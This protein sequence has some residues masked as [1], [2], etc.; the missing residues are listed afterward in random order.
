MTT[1]IAEPTAANRTPA[2]TK[3]RRRRFPG[4]AGM[5]FTLPLMIVTAAVIAYPLLWTLNLSF[6]SL[7]LLKRNSKSHY[8]GLSNY[9]EVLGSSEFRHAMITTVGFVV[10]MI[11]LEFIL[12]LA[13]ALMLNQRLRGIST[14][15][16]IFCLPLLLAPSVAGLQFRFL[17]ADQY[18][19]INAILRHVGITGPQWLVSVWAARTAIV[20]SDLWLATPFVVLVLL[21]GMASLPS[22]PFEAARIDGARADQVLRYVMLPMLRPAILIILVIRLADGFRIF[23]LV[24]IL[25]GGGP[26]TSTD[27]MSTYIYR[28]T[29]V[30]AHFAQGAAAS[31]I[32]VAV[33]ALISFVC[34]RL[35][36]PRS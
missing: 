9:R 8:V 1:R 16:L 4:R 15:R 5:L 14:F 7:N 13:I 10:V 19:A 6:R 17:F 35:L 3:R 32:L 30:R 29:F 23:D 11:S 33:V 22:E 12:G 21:A 20:L 24:Y 34:L 25:T 31:F 18:G 28:E 26:G 2:T 36:R 27:V